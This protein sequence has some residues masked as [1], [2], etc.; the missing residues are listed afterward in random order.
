MYRISYFNV[1]EAMVTREDTV[2]ATTLL[3]AEALA[4]KKCD[5]MTGK[6]PALLRKSEATLYD[7]LIAGEIAGS[8]TIQRL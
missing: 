1:G 8:L 3:A 2:G 4:A 7:V 6:R 5:T